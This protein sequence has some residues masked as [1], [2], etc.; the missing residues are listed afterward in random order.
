MLLYTP[1]ALLIRLRCHAAADAFARD[2]M[3]PCCTCCHYFRH[4]ADCRLRYAFIAITTLP[5]SLLFRCCSGRLRYA[6]SSFF[7]AD[8]VCYGHYAAFRRHY[9][10]PASAAGAY[11]AD[12]YA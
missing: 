9:L 7:I 12:A 3:L 2:A 4:Y 8:A 5:L 6:V 1:L 11:A 10:M